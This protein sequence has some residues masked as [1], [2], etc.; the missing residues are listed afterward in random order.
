MMTSTH[1]PVVLSAIVA[2]SAAMTTAPAT[3]QSGPTPLAVVA[4][5][6]LLRQWAPAEGYY[7][8]GRDTIILRIVEGRLF[9]ELPDASVELVLKDGKLVAASTGP[10][11]GPIEIDLRGRFVSYRGT[12]FERGSWQEPPLPPPAIASVIGDYVNGVRHIVIFERNGRS[13]ASLSPGVYTPMSASG[14]GHWTISSGSASATSKRLT[15]ITKNGVRSVR[16]DGVAFTL[17]PV[18][19]DRPTPLTFE[20]LTR[21]RAIALQAAPPHESGKRPSDLISLTSI[22]PTIHRNIVYATPNNFI[23]QPVYTH[24]V[25]MMQRPA[26]VALA[27]VNAALSRDGYGLFVFDAYRPWYVTKIFWDASLPKNKIFVADPAEGSRHNRGCAVDLSLFKI[28]TGKEVEMPSSYD[29]NSPRSNPTYS[30]GTTHQR[31]LR[32]KLRTAM[33]AGDFTVDD[34]EW[35]HF[36]YADWA[37]YPIGNVEISE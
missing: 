32:E 20:Q 19:E 5:P 34:V 6:S 7:I 26:A 2:L 33:V 11:I 3:A 21:L 22:D 31:W 17:R 9:V 1:R 36:N 35:W 37:S 8:D 10:T 29:E 14:Q 13:Y 12:R 24:A 27:R 4:T 23:G 15:V 18:T 25:A 28:A 16:V 30:G